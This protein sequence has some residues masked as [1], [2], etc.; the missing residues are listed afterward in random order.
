MSQQDIRSL[1]GK[2][3]GGGDNERQKTGASAERL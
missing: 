1:Q 3:I 2:K